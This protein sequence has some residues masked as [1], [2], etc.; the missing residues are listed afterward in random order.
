MRRKP[1]DD[2]A[3]DAWLRFLGEAIGGLRAAARRL[4]DTAAGDVSE[5]RPGWFGKSNRAVKGA[6]LPDETSISQA[7]VEEMDEIRAAQLI[8]SPGEVAGEPDLRGMDFHYEVARRYDPA[9]GP[10]AQETDIQLAIHRERLDLRMEAKKLTKPADIAADYLGAKGLGRFDDIHA[11][12]TLE[13]FGGMVAYVTDSDAST[14]T[15]MIS[16]GICGSMTPERVTDTVVSG[17]SFVTTVHVR[18]ID[19]ELFELKGWFT[20]HVFHMVLEFEASP[21][22]R[23]RRHRAGS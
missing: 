11:P 9:I 23:R 17:E 13:R 2:L 10:R 19:I 14:W 8:A 22:R 4:S 18:D 16:A 1:A 3:N 12:Y 15:H 21:G 20:T 5:Q 7:L 6:K